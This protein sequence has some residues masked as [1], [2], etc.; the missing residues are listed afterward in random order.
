MQ[1][2]VSGGKPPFGQDVNGILNAL[3]AHIFAQQAGQLYNYSSDVSTAIGGYPVGTM[4]ESTDGV[5]V[6]F[7]ILADNTSDPDANGAGW[8]PMFNYGYTT[9]AVTGGTVTLTRLEARR[10]VIVLTGT[11]VSNLQVVLPNTLQTWLIVNSTT[12]SF[13][14]TVRTLAGTGV[15]VSQGGFGSPLGVY[16]DGTNI[17]PTVAPLSVPIDQAA[18][19]LSIAQRTNNGYLLAAYFN[20]SSGLENPTVGAIFVQNSA[21]DGYLR[22]ISIANLELQMFLQNFSGQCTAS[23]V[24]SLSSLNG[25][26]TASQV[27][28]LS[29]LNGQVTDGQVPASAVL[30][31]DL[32]G[33][34][35]A[36]NNVVGSRAL[37]AAYTNNTGRPI[38]AVVCVSLPNFASGVFYVDGV[39]VGA[40]T[41]GGSA[42]VLQ[43]SVVI[44]NGSTYEMATSGAVILDAWSELR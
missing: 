35:Q 22:K 20:Q 7:N 44:P 21:A 43:V 33:T 24:P 40:N 16:G 23:Q 26:C 14:T 37:N 4:L 32:G 30:Q 34:G 39:I 13:T 3:S 38:Q 9:K 12:G 36:W 8:V 17:Y 1:P 28:P 25:A 27:P 2:E 5:T 15:T 6:W 10:G 11:L 19:P 42:E 29:G 31:Y 41:A 18:T